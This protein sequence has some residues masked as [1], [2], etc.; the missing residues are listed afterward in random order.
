LNES[1]NKQLR[2]VRLIIIGIVLLVF[3]GSFIANLLLFRQASA[4]YREAS[5]VRLDPYGLKYSFYDPNTPNSSDAPLVV[6]F[7]DSRAQQWPA[8]QEARFRF[9]NR[10]I[11]GQTT[12][13]VRGRFDAHVRALKPTVLIVQAG[14]NDLKT[15]ALFPERREPIV[16]ECKANLREIVRRATEEGEVV[17]VT[18]IFPTAPVSLVGR[19]QWS[20]EIDQ[21]VGEV[22]ED[23]KSLASEKVVV[24][25]AYSVLQ[26][27][28]HVPGDLAVDT[29]HVNGKAYE[30]LNRE[31]A[32]LLE[33]AAGGYAS[34]P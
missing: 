2:R 33:R 11:G 7:G 32:K 30:R 18:T 19:M 15:I 34:R 23:L 21:A 4:S 29:L 1:R 5:D 10:G 14:I 13:Q 24:F 31:L 16:A 3:V 28:G 27:G 26:S 9:L 22:N 17:V 25:D 20:P 12:E 6:F 8:P